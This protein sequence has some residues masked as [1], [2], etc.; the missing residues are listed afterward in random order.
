MKKI[1]PC[2][3]LSI[4]FTLAISGN[5]E[6]AVKDLRGVWV[7][8][9]Y[10]LDYPSSPTTSP[11]T[12]KSEADAILDQC[13]EM[14]MNAVFL[15]VRPSSDA[16]Y[17][18]DYYPW[19]AYLTGSQG[20][21]PSEGFDPLAYWVT[22]AHNRGIELHAWLNPYR[23]ASSESQ[24][25]S[26]ADSN[27]AK[28]H[29][30]WVYKYNN[31]YYLD[32]GLPEV[33]QYIING[34]AEILKKY[35]VDGIHIDDYFYPGDGNYDDNT[36]A[37][38]GSGLSKGDWRRANNDAL[39]Q[40]LNNAAHVRGKVFGVSPA[41]IWANKSSISTGSDTKGNQTYFSGYADTRKWVKSGW[42]DYIC[43]QIYWA[44]G[45]SIADYKVLANWWADVVTGTGVELYIGM[46]DYRYAESGSAKWTNISTIKNQLALNATIPQI[47]GEV[48]FRFGNLMDIPA[49]KN[50]YVI[51]Y[52]ETPTPRLIASTEPHQSYIKGD[53]GLFRPDDS[54]TRGEISTI[55]ARLMVN[56]NGSLFF[57]EGASYPNIFSDV[58]S[59]AWYFSA[60]G[61]MEY[62]KVLN[63]Y[64]DGIF[65]PTAKV[66][67]AECAAIISRF[68]AVSSGSGNAFT[69]V[70]S[71]HWAKSSI[72]T[73][74][75]LGYVEGYGDGTFRPNANITRTEAV[76]MVN[77]VL[78]RIPTAELLTQAGGFGDVPQNHWGY[79]DILEASHPHSAH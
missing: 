4:I 65:R 9:V 32:G 39:I 74:A 41:G 55:M 27:P 11:S 30:D 42:L 5:G 53:E 70:P 62:N 25:N 76:A 12:L 37:R 73:C 47:T 23:V 75:A 21:A 38:Y 78:G 68:A 35:D 57:N 15:Q 24:Y 6:A 56:G 63:G 60:V 46:A 14:G 8:S 58:P 77:R 72:E 29:P 20:R 71:S 40:G 10:N 48:H 52:N 7:S 36:F 67:R 31:T 61:F 43:P 22:A 51:E 16:L 64:E 59:S 54:I 18:S 45:Y 79:L 49:L 2:L 28:Q 33:R 1:I 13:V 26:L 69:D 66:T 17:K 3:I 19:S 34:A 44:I 50:L